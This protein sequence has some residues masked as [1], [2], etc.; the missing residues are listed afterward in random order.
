MFYCLG[1]NYETVNGVKLPE[2]CIR[3][4]SELHH[5]PTLSEFKAEGRR[6]LYVIPMVFGFLMGPPV[7]FSSSKISS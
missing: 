7:A 1:V 2:L 6:G 3:Q 5:R 4:H